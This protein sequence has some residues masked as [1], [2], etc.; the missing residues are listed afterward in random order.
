MPKAYMILVRMSF[1]IYLIHADTTFFDRCLF[2]EIACIEANGRKLTEV[3]EI[4]QEIFDHFNNLF[5][6]DNTN[7]P[8]S[9]H[10]EFKCL[11]AE[12]Y[13]RLTAEFSDEEIKEAVW[14]C[15]SSKSPRPDGINFGFL[16]EFWGV[17][18]DDF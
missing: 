2:K 13:M 1:L 6:E 15:E 9:Q 5:K 12:E 10:A 18:K 17:I 4:K 7:R 11:G 14:D 16:K 8:S 3:Q